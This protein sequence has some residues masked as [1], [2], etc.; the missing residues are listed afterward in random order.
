MDIL[1]IILNMFDIIDKNKKYIKNVWYIKQRPI[2]N[3]KL[4]NFVS[5]N[6]IVVLTWLRRSWKSSIL[7]KYLENKKNIFYFSKE[8]DPK[9]KIKNNEDL[10]K[11]FEECSKSFSKIKYVVIDEIQDIK[12]WEIFI[13]YIYALKKYKIIITWSNSKLLS[14]ELSTFLAWRYHE[15]SVY[16]LNFNEF[17][18]FKWES[19]STDIFKEYLI[20]WWLPEIVFLN[21]LLVKQNYLEM[22]KNSIILKDII[23]RYN[24]RDYSVFESIVKF[25]SDNIANLTTWRNINWFLKNEW[26]KI[27]LS[28]ILDYINFCIQSFFIYKVNRYDLRWKKVLEINNKY[29]L[30][31]L[32]IRSAILWDFTT[33]NIWAL[34]ENFVFNELKKGWYEVFIWNYMDLEIDFVAKKDWIVKYFQVSYLL[35]DDL[36]FKREISG[37]I[38]INDLY[39]KFIVTLDE[40]RLWNYEWVEVIWIEGF[41]KSI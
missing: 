39:Q 35:S 12:N 6:N 16:P 36:T 17:L 10:N 19:Y 26:V 20:Y 34:L 8:I 15:I 31:D 28:T 4:D 23:N 38:K 41:L 5:K 29:Y 1:L 24:I 14:S 7:L 32:W 3:Q 13:R 9:N 18:D 11:L 27:V 25:L 33:K 37:L 30:S 22:I 2:Y 21:D 40:Y